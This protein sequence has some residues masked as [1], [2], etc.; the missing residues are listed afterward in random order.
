MQKSH[1][2]VIQVSCRIHTNSF[3]VLNANFPG[4]DQVSLI[5]AFHHLSLKFNK[6]LVMKCTCWRNTFGEHTEIMS[7]NGYWNTSTLKTLTLVERQS[8]CVLSW[9]FM[10]WHILEFLTF[11]ILQFGENIL[12][13]GE[14]IHLYLCKEP[15]LLSCKW[16]RPNQWN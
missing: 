12:Q 16:H 13:F 7:S 1:L 3:L 10:L 11:E 15:I 9:D 6:N 5:F 4:Y 14:N 2:F 8:P